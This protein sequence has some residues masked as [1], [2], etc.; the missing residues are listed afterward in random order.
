MSALVRLY[1]RAWRDRYEEEFLA[2][3]EARPPTVGDRLDIVRGAIDARTRPQVRRPEAPEPEPANAAP[4]DTVLVRRLG[5]AALAGGVV[6][7]MAWSLATVAA[8]VVYDGYGP[9]RDGSAALPVLFLSVILLVGGLFGHLIA[10]PASRRAA[11]AG[12][13]V[14]IPFLLLWSAGPWVI[15]FALIAMIAL[16]AFAIGSLGTSHWSVAA[17]AAMAVGIGGSIAFAL[18]TIGLV[19]LGTEVPYEMMLL[20]T[21]TATPIWLAVGGSLIRVRPIVPAA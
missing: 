16:V 10:L 9:H 12:V 1:P 19:N 3:L 5:Y 4:D 11:R 2:L 7:L 14:A 15:W 13:V 8:P 18:L 17:C 21:A 6:W 20:V